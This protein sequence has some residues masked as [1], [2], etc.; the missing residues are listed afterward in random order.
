MVDNMVHIFKLDI[1]VIDDFMTPQP[2]YSMKI[3][4]SLD[5]PSRYL[6][7]SNF[8]ITFEQE[9]RSILARFWVNFS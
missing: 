7:R 3:F 8:C 2:I 9:F 4:V 5:D 6:Q 1:E